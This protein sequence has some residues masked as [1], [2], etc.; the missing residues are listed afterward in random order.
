MPT[1]VIVEPPPFPGWP[2]LVIRRLSAAKRAEFEGMGKANLLHVVALHLNLDPDELEPYG[3]WLEIISSARRK[4]LATGALFERLVWNLDR[5]IE[6]IE[7]GHLSS[8]PDGNFSD[9]AARLVYFCEYETWARN[10]NLP[11]LFP[12]QDADSI[13]GLWFTVPNV[14][15]SRLLLTALQA[16]INLLVGLPFGKYIF[17]TKRSWPRPV[18]FKAEIKRIDP[19]LDAAQVNRVYSLARDTRWGSGRRPV[20]E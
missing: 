18:R 8:E 19:T 7:R 11:N 10:G 17:E 2:Q 1:A 4:E 12:Y 3:E 9:P 20:D 13:P 5:A 6:A 15:P 14:R 16:T